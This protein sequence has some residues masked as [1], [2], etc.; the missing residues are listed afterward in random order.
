MY[1]NLVLYVLQ[2][3]TRYKSVGTSKYGKVD[4]YPEPVI[5]SIASLSAFTL[6]LIKE[7]PEA[8]KNL[9]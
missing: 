8:G 9:S 3:L 7:L 2:R 5:S 1:V 4:G 6:N